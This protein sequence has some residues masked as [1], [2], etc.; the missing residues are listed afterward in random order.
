MSK[1]INKLVPNNRANC[2]K[3]GSNICI[4]MRRL[5]LEFWLQQAW[6]SKIMNK[7]V[8]NNRAN[9]VK[10]GPNICIGIRRLD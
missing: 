4:N 7:L 3:F 6:M 5:D 8:P 1:I 10:F 9:W 2:A